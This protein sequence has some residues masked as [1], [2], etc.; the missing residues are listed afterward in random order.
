MIGQDPGTQWIATGG[1]STLDKTLVRKS[2][3]IQGITVNPS[4]YNND[5]TS[6]FETLGTEWDVYDQ[7][8]ATYLGSHTMSG[9][10]SNIY[11]T[12]YEDLDVSNVTSYEITGLDPETTYYYVV[13]AYDDYSQTSGNSGEI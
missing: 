2:S 12:G 10:P 8:T 7:N 5:D 6:A 11:V 4:G 1:Y 9:S 3:V 13:R